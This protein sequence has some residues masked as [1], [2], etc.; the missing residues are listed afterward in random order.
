MESWLGPFLFADPAAGTAKVYGPGTQGIRYIAV[1]DV[2]E[3]AV[4]A[5]TVPSA[6]NATIPFGGPE[7]ISQRDAVLLFEEEYGKPFAV[8]DIP[9]Q[10]LDAQWQTATDPF[11]KSFAALML[12]VARGLGGDVAVP[13]SEFGV[14]MTPC[15]DFVHRSAT[16]AQALGNR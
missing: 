6:R 7:A 14:R 11:Q 12:A 4:K 13:S 10:A 3:M 2:A 8:I 5:L 9:E 16:P 1:G 15:R